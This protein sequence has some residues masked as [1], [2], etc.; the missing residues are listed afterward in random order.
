MASNGKDLFASKATWGVLIPIIT[1]LL[2]AIGITI[3]DINEDLASQTIADVVGGLVFLWGQLTRKAPITTVAGMPVPG[4]G[5][6]A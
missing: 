1:R 5:G 4:K 2:S 6:T 3:P